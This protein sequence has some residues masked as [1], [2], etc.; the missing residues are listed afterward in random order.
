MYVHI[1]LVTSG[2]G[3]FDVNRKESLGGKETIENDFLRTICR[4][5]FGRWLHCIFGLP[6][7]V[8]IFYNW[9][10]IFSV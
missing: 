4:T 2:I 5:Y 10:Y 3:A 7:S 9:G 1:G 6:V 8:G